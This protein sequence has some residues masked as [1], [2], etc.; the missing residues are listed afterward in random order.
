MKKDCMALSL[1]RKK[2]MQ[3]CIVLNKKKQFSKFT[4]NE[5]VR[6]MLYAKEACKYFLNKRLLVLPGEKK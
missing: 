1:R 3:L 4:G 6:H 5:E 2:Y